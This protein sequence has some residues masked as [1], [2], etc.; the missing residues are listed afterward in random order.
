M[1]SE[2]CPIQ[3]APKNR[4][5]YLLNPLGTIFF[6]ECLCCT[7]SVFG[8]EIGSFSDLIRLTAAKENKFNPNSPISL[9][10]W[11]WQKP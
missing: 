2:Y 5:R 4:I 8:F 3:Q 11:W 1:N 7:V 9:W 6:V 10:F